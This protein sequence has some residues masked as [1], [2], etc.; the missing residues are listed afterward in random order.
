MKFLLLALC[1]CIA[2]SAWAAPSAV[3][4]TIRGGKLGHVPHTIRISAHVLS[5][6]HNRRICIEWVAPKASGR[7]CEDIDGLAG[8]LTYWRDI[9]FRAPG[10]YSIR[11]V[12]DRDDNK[13]Q[14]SNIEQVRVIGFGEEIEDG[15][16]ATNP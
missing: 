10:V 8:R 12:L 7:G 5:D 4:I 1:L 6:E 16:D 3:T 2:G 9:T 15:S 14:V 13:I 11:A